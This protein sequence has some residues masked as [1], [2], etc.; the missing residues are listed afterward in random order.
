MGIPRH[1][2]IPLQNDTKMF[3]QTRLR[4]NAVWTIKANGGSQVPHVAWSSWC[5][6]LETPIHKQANTE[7]LS[8]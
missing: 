3:G 8:E 7:H 5:S 2:D 6:S 1:F 4:C